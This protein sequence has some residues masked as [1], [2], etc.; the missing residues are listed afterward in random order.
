M[1]PK[2]N[3]KHIIDAFTDLKLY[4]FIVRF[5][6]L[7]YIELSIKDADHCF[8]QVMTFCANVGASASNVFGPIILQELIGVCSLVITFAV[9]KLTLLY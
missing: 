8:Q 3:T 2:F 7:P 6:I 5:N 4:L 9:L 1:N